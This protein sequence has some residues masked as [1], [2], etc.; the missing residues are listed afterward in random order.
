MNKSAKKIKNLEGMKYNERRAKE[1]EG[2][3]SLAS[4][5]II[6]FIIRDSRVFRSRIELHTGSKCGSHCLVL[7]SKHSPTPIP[8]GFVSISYHHI[9]KYHW[10]GKGRVVSFNIFFGRDISNSLRTSF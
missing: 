5:T 3:G 7:F 10:I 1:E 4:K 9:N 2:V 8:T 6:K